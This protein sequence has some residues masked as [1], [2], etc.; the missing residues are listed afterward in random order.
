MLLLSV[1]FGDGAA[2]RDRS[3]ACWTLAGHCRSPNPC[4]VHPG[5]VSRCSGAR[6]PC[7]GMGAVL[8]GPGSLVVYLAKHRHP[9]DRAT[10]LGPYLVAGLA[11][12]RRADWAVGVRRL[13]LGLPRLR[14]PASVVPAPCGTPSSDAEISESH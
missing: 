12:D 10:V 13:V 4:L 14:H 1:P 7:R 3:A 5:C 11:G 6:P 9:F 8:D 2:D